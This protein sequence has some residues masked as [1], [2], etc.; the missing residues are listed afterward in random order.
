MFIS[1]G[2][3]PASAYLVDFSLLA[4]NIPWDDQA[5]MEQFHFGLHNDVE[6]L[7]LTFPEEL[8]LLTKA[9]SAIQ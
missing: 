6:Y 5:L 8:K 7:L 4:N 3:H 2:D 9:S 1:Q